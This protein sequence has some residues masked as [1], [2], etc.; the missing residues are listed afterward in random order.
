MATSAGGAGG[1][2][3][4]Q[5]LVPETNTA[6]NDNNDLQLVKQM[7]THCK[8]N[9]GEGK[10]V[11]S[12]IKQTID[13]NQQT[14]IT[15]F[16]VEKIRDAAYASVQ[17]EKLGAINP[18]E[19]AIKLVSAETDPAKELV[20]QQLMNN[21]TTEQLLEF[22]VQFTENGNEPSK[23]S[24]PDGRNFSD[25]LNR[26]CN[27]WMRT[28]YD[29]SDIGISHSTAGRF[30]AA[31][32][33][34]RSTKGLTNLLCDSLPQGCESIK[35]ATEVIKGML[36][37]ALL[38]VESDGWGRLATEKLIPLIDKCFD[39]KGDLSTPTDTASDALVMVRLCASVPMLWQALSEHPD[40]LGKFVQIEEKVKASKVPQLK[41]S[42]TYNNNYPAECQ[43]MGDQH[44]PSFFTTLHTCLKL[45]RLG[46][47]GM[48]MGVAVRCALSALKQL[49]LKIAMS[50]PQH[51]EDLVQLVCLIG[52]FE[53]LHQTLLRRLVEIDRTSTTIWDT[54]PQHVLAALGLRC[55]GFDIPEESIANFDDVAWATGEHPMQT[56]QNGN[57][58]AVAIDGERHLRPTTTSQA[59]TALK[60]IRTGQL[61]D[62][63]PHMCSLDLGDRSIVVFVV[64]A[65]G[66]SVTIKPSQ[67]F[68]CDVTILLAT[69]F[70]SGGIGSCSNAINLS[71]VVDKATVQNSKDGTAKKSVVVA[72]AL[73]DFLLNGEAHAGGELATHGKKLAQLL[74][75]PKVSWTA[76][77]TEKAWSKDEN[78]NFK[79]FPNTTKCEGVEKQVVHFPIQIKGPD[80]VISN[81]DLLYL[82][83]LLDSCEGRDM[84]LHG[85]TCSLESD[86]QTLGYYNSN[87]QV[88]IAHPK[89]INAITK[90]TGC[91]T[92]FHGAL[93]AG[94]AKGEGRPAYAYS[95]YTLVMPRSINDH[96]RTCVER[97]PKPP[98]RDDKKHIFYRRPPPR[99]SWNNPPTTGTWSMS[100]PGQPKHTARESACDL[101]PK[102][103]KNIPEDCDRTT[104]AM[105][106]IEAPEAFK[107][108]A[109]PF[110]TDKFTVIS[111][112]CEVPRSAYHHYVQACWIQVKDAEVYDWIHQFTTMSTGC[113]NS[114]GMGMDTEH[115]YTFFTLSD[116]Q[117][118]SSG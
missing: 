56:L 87:V 41:G 89:H 74:A 31:R 68:G 23:A 3:E 2:G 86:L 108:L 70:L 15:E 75:T 113:I 80:A 40:A 22:V 13:P 110:M 116:L 21:V 88:N 79:W 101:F 67:R 33:A 7:I 84:A 10:D 16:L 81:F 45:Q 19:L 9:I 11:R 4:A 104:T 44:W 111:S 24:L 29:S 107:D 27:T 95:T 114:E 53:V 51:F 54:T 59:T 109:L 64:P 34:K 25:C 42:Y 82:R 26:M 102:V 38:G 5:V 85:G 72:K 91:L 65:K 99:A 66:E 115:R 46:E 49:P 118:A 35:E 90:E 71:L 103:Q 55:N 47:S 6:T 20:R 1:A 98:N 112:M 8:N 12:I 30:K 37:G 61:R 117:Q 58:A 93:Q 48:M 106:L 78:G 57:Y 18:V 39:E 32:T 63:S 62:A 17:K 28:H 77:I 105:I 97:L 94:S 100:K 69:N 73:K 36:G 43:G 14:H 92:I 60:N 52:N 83:D 96:L 50:P 76:P